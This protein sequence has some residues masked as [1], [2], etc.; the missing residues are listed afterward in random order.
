MD[1][2]TIGFG[3]GL[4]T[5]I[6]M[7]F[8]IVAR[9]LRGGM[10]LNSDI[11]VVFDETR[12]IAYIFPVKRVGVG[13]Y[14]PLNRRLA[15]DIVALLEAEPP[16]RYSTPTGRQVILGMPIGYGAAVLGHP[17]ELPSTYAALAIAMGDEVKC[18]AFDEACMQQIIA[19]VLNR[20]AKQEGRIAMGGLV[21]LAVEIPQSDALVMFTRMV[22]NLMRRVFELDV[23]AKSQ[24]QKAV[25]SLTGGFVRLAML[26]QLVLIIITLMIGVAVAM[27]LF[28]QVNFVNIFGGL[29]T[30]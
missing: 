5:G 12:N 6:A 14:V 21:R 9:R 8:F 4:F 30:G 2:F 29:V 3:L 27:I 24:L 28:G 16:R 1:P 26:R 25:E 23:V 19:S 22:Q 17:M 11:A 10:F 18:R 20:I 7:V 13:I 15:G